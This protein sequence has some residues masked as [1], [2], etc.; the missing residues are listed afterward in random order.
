ML[1]ILITHNEHA[2]RNMCEIAP[3]HF[4]HFK[5]SAPHTRVSRKCAVLG[6]VHMMSAVSTCNTSQ[7][8]FFFFFPRAGWTALAYHPQHKEST[9]WTTE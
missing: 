7:Q 4:F 3:R 1:D 5:I 2:L 8:E 6:L 9:C